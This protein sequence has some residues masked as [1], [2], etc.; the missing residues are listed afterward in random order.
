MA[1]QANIVF[2]KNQFV[3]TLADGRCIQQAD[4]LELADALFHAGVHAGDVQYEWSAGQRMITAGQQVALRAAIR[5]KE[6]QPQPKLA[7]AA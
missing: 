2:F 3:A 5:R 6:H 4:L 7:I 1:T